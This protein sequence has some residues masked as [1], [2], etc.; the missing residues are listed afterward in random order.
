MIP[1]EPAGE[2]SAPVISV[3]VATYNSAAT[4]R[5]AIGSLVV[6]DFDD[7]EAWIIGDACSD[8]SEGVVRSFD[9]PRL[10]WR[11]LAQNSGIQS[12]PNNEGL[13]LARGRFVA[14]LGHD[15]LWFPWHLSSL[16]AAASKSAADFV[17]ATC[18][19]LRPDGSHRVSG[20]IGHGRSHADQYTPPSS[21][22]H[23]REIASSI[24]NW[25]DPALLGCGVDLDFQ[26][27]VA[28]AGF[29]CHDVSRISVLKFPSSWWRNY[30]VGQVHP[31]PAYLRR[32]EDEPMALEREL[33][34]NLVARYAREENGARPV[35]ELRRAAR[36]LLRRIA[37]GYGRDRWPMSE[38]LFW[39]QQR[40]RRRDR[41]R[42]GLPPLEEQRNRGSDS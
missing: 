40:F 33:M 16:L 20:P 2:Q 12:G 41:P 30:A 27:R 42:R 5:C 10:H 39:R 38:F 19:L 28:L 1:S 37:D 26:R 34:E 15:D 24:G 25:R 29:A 17:N 36:A 7:F 14:Y 32:L 13:R 21:W 35:P 18:L 9:D 23:R 31:Q 8:D 6:Q 22:L 4:L 3:I 11:N